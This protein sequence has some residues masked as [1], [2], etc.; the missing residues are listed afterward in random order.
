MIKRM[1]AAVLLA[2][3][4]TAATTTPATAGMVCGTLRLIDPL[5]DIRACAPTNV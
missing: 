5:Q 1:I 4:L 3:G 2:I